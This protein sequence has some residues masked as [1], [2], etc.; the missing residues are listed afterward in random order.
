[1]KF[2]EQK[3]QSIINHYSMFLETTKQGVSQNY[4]MKKNHP[5]RS[6]MFCKL[7]KA[8]YGCK[9]TEKNIGIKYKNTNLIKHV[10][11]LFNDMF[12]LPNATF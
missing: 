1:M 11:S 12:H 8:Q 7:I 4:G 10:K 6:R 2:R 9:D 5:L 3:I